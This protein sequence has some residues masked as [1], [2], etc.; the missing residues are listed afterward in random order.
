MATD[1]ERRIDFD[2]LRMISGGVFDD[3]PPGGGKR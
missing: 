3:P 2:A 1:V